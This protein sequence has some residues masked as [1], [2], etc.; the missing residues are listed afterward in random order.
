MQDM[1]DMDNV[2][3]LSKFYGAESL[4]ALR[5]SYDEW[6]ASYDTDTLALA[7]MLPPTIAGMAGKHIPNGIRGPVLDVGCGT[8]LM[9]SV[10]SILGYGPLDG[11]D[12]SPGMLE[13]ASRSG[14]YR[15]LYEAAAGPDRLAMPDNSY[16]V[17][18]AAGVFTLGH[19]GPE[20]FDELLRVMRP[21]GLIV[22]SATLPVLDDAFHAKIQ[23]LSDK[24][25]WRLV[26]AS[27]PFATA[28]NSAD[29][30]Q[31]RV[32]VYRVG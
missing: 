17:A 26:E 1:S 25:R 21:S 32:F 14:V 11:L 19:A 20:A 6:A 15:K 29:A 31:G 5:E 7:R 28:L 12:L 2:P 8:G 27:S 13:G 22:F 3:D 23:T 30:P 9:G 4:D 24:G 16:A 18:V 10:L